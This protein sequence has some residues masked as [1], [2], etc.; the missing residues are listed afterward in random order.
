MVN[1]MQPV[2]KLTHSIEDGFSL[3]I[4]KLKKYPIGNIDNCKMLNIEIGIF[5]KES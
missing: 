5:C 2:I 1:P 3:N 4:L